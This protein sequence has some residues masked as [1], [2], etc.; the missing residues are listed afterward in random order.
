MHPLSSTPIEGK[1]TKVI[2]ARVIS[3]D[4]SA[5]PPGLAAL[6]PDNHGTEVPCYFHC[7]PNG[8]PGLQARSGMTG[9]HMPAVSAGRIRPRKMY[10]LQ[11]RV[12]DP[13]AGPVPAL[14]LN[15][16]GRAPTA[17]GPS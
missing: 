5:V 6:G 3:R 2:M 4:N 10:K 7:I 1:H 14:V 16:V 11:A 17:Q 9:F 15:T 13:R 12:R 8:M